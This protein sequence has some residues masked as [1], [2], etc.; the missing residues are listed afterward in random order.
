[1]VD[2]HTAVGIHAA[3]TSPS[4]R[5]E[6]HV[7]CIATAHAGE[8]LLLSCAQHVKDLFGLR[9]Q[10]SLSRQFCKQRACPLENWLTCLHAR[11]TQTCRVSSSLNKHGLASCGLPRCDASA[12]SHLAFNACPLQT[13]DWEKRLR[14]LVEAPAAPRSKL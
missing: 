12:V 5:N 8:M 11:P 10:Q 4:L 13:E 7:V 2:P 3:I 14:S 9:L 1:L 6:R